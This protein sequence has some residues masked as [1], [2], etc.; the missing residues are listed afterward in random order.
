MLKVQTGLFSVA[1]IDDSAIAAV[2]VAEDGDECAGYQVWVRTKNGETIS[3][4][5]DCDDYRRPVLQSSVPATIRK[6]QPEPVNVKEAV[7]SG[8]IVIGIMALIVLAEIFIPLS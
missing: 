3:G 1:Y 6:T 8:V 5:V 2:D 7:W 4:S